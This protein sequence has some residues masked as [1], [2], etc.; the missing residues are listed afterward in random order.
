MQAGGG[1]RLERVGREQGADGGDNRPAQA[2]QHDLLALP[3]HA[4]DQDHVDGRAQALDH[5]DLQ[6][7]ALQLADEHEA[8]RHHFL[9]AGDGRVSS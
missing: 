6:H 1:G 5:L 7:R 2:A 4:V 3:Q 9:R 8:L